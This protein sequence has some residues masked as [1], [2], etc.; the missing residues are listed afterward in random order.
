MESESKEMQ[1][2]IDRMVL[3]R[4]IHSIVRA[5]IWIYGIESGKLENFR[6]ELSDLVGRAADEIENKNTPLQFDVEH[7]QKLLTTANSCCGLQTTARKDSKY[8]QY[9]SL[10]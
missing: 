1:K 10:S 4:N 6:S 7:V 2:Q 5:C 8:Q 3:E 9:S